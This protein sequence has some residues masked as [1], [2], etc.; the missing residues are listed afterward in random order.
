MIKLTIKIARQINLYF[1]SKVF[2]F[3]CFVVALVHYC[4]EGCDANRVDA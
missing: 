1:V 3:V 4:S 2:H